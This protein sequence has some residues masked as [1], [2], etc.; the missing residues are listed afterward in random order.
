MGE[1]A[2]EAW[3]TA[4]VSEVQDRTL[5]LGFGDRNGADSP[6]SSPL[7]A[8]LSSSSRL[9][10][11]P[12]RAS[13]STSTL[14]MPSR[15]S[16]S[17]CHLGALRSFA[18]EPFL[19]T[20]TGEDFILNDPLWAEV[21]APNGTALVEG[22]TCYRKVNFPVSQSPNSSLTGS[23]APALRQHPREDLVVRS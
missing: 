6:T 5:G 20:S 17:S 13:R 10:R 19:R 2:S 3:E 12:E 7:S 14:L 22:D 9:S 16:W 21:Y 18:D 15:V 11:S 1:V 8:G 4:L 23:S